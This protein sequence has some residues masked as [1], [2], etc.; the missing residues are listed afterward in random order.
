MAT[1]LKNWEI[2]TW[3]WLKREALLL[4]LVVVGLIYYFGGCRKSANTPKNTSDTTSKTTQNPQPTIIMPAY[5]P[6]QSGGV[7]YLPIPQSSQGLIPASNL[8]DLTNQVKDLSTRIEELGKAYYAVK[9]YGDSIQLK[10]TSGTRVGVVKLDQT[11]SENTLKS[12]QPTYQ[13]SFPH[14]ITTITNTIYPKPVNQVY[15][16]VGVES[17]ITVPSFNQLDLGLLLK[18][19]QDNI[20]GFGGYYDLHT[21][22]TGVDLHYFKK[23]TIKKPKLLP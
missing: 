1:E 23:I 10:D 4:L 17:S 6:Q 20:F 16:G 5:P 3:N 12:T 21:K 19:K 8:A 22:Q 2:S 18:N 14:T 7:V 13:L 11:V 9:H 15:V